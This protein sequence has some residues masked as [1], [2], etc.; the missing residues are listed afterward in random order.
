[1]RVW[2]MARA[3]MRSLFLR[4]RRDSDLQ[5]E[6]RLHIDREA[7]RLE[8]TGLAPD[9]ARLRA[10]QT[11]G[12]I[13]TTKEACRDVRG[14]LWLDE[15]LRDVRFASRSF[16]RTPLVALTI[17]G[18]VGLGLGL[19]AVVF[20]ILNLYVF[21]PDSVQNPDELFAVETP[22]SEY[23]EPALFTQVE[24]EAFLD[25]TSFFSDAFAQSADVDAW[26]DGRRLEG[27]FV[28][29]NFFDVLGVRAALGRTFTL[30]DDQPSGMP[31]VV[32]SHRAWTT[33]FDA[34]ADVVGTTVR[35]N[36][37]PARIIGVMP[38]GFR[39][40]MVAALDF[41]APLAH[42]DTLFPGEANASTQDAFIVGRLASGQSR[43]EAQVQLQAWDARRAADSGVSRPAVNLTLEPR[44][45][46]I[47]RPLEA[48]LL[49]VPLFFAFGLILVIGCANVANLLFARA[50]A[51]QREIG[52]RL[53]I[54][55]SRRRIIRQLLVESLLLSFASAAVAY[56]LSRVALETIVH[57]AVRS[58]PADFGNIR[59]KIPPGDW[60]VIVFLL[61]GALASTLFFALAP[62]LQATRLDLVRAIR[63]DAVG[64]VRPGRPRD[65]LVTLQVAGSALLLVCAAIFLRSVWASAAVDP[66]IRTADTINVTVLTE[67]RR[68]AVLDII[69]REP[70]V[71]A[72]AASWPNGPEAAT[73]TIEPVV[74]ESA[75]D[76]AAAT[77]P[78]VRY[79]LVSPEYFDVLGIDILQGRSFLDTERDPAAAVAIVSAATAHELWPGA[80][81]IGQVMRFGPEADAL[82]EPPIASA[83]S[84]RSV[85]VVGV[86]RDVAGFRLAGVRP[87]AADVYL[88]VDVES[89][90]T[91][92]TLRVH[93]DPASARRTLIDHAAAVD[94]NM[95]DVST[96][97]TLASLE[98]YLLSIPFWLT[99]VLGAI[100]LLLTVSGLFGV[101]SYLVAQRS[102]EIGV[103]MALGATRRAVALHV[104]SQSVRPVLGG[105]LTGGG[106]V[107][108]LGAALLA[109]PAA[110]TIGTTVGLFDPVAYAVGLSTIS[111]AC[112]CGAV[113]PALRATRIEPL[114][115]LK[116]E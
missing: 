28:T 77:R 1:M 102:R 5:E 18:T 38:D 10:L 22:R 76:A 33:H 62:A 16:R 35:V 37:T 43:D 95:A 21:L 53:A 30:A 89:A 51:R 106:L 57:V 52:V 101:L 46:T 11:F 75:P 44:T 96:L 103:R 100:G 68:A 74:V 8:A 87:W 49:F 104:L 13:D 69:R 26:I 32:I 6:L 71:H 67:D 39:G 54:G 24:Y 20:S 61:G 109:T 114:L 83:A 85:V 34:D 40:L 27:A 56:A 31:L 88:P 112:F 60:R 92:L 91:T 29:G 111:V 72:V 110:D 79:R 48:A 105:L 2:H 63:G 78:T 81:A 9:A 17:T 50:V 116:Q 98:S 66:G 64:A 41:W 70:A 86:A 113:V 19:V 14:R 42:A 7:E 59:I 90:R 12:G 82:G 94:P 3:R 99:L 84:P 97:Q 93:G 15:L 73:A 55:A 25:E 80:S 58:F 107:A 23:T 65:I 36:N 4:H 45:G 108:A 47:P 115:A